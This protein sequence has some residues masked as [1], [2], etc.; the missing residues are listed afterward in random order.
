MKSVFVPLML[1]A[2]GLGGCRVKLDVD[3][4]THRWERADGNVNATAADDFAAGDKVRVKQLGIDVD[5]ITFV[6][7]GG[8]TVK[9]DANIT[10]VSVSARVVGIGYGA[11]AEKDAASDANGRVA[12]S[13]KVEKEGDTW[14]VSCGQAENGDVDSGCEY[15]DVRVPAGSAD[16]PTQLSVDSAVGGVEIRIGDAASIDAVAGLGKIYVEANPVQ[17]AEIKLVSDGDEVE[18]KVP[19]GLNADAVQLIG[20]T[21][22][23]EPSTCDFEGASFDGTTFQIGEQGVG[24]RSI[25]ADAGEDGRVRLRK[26]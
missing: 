15:L 26:L 14:V 22:G 12:E 3:T 2:V 9:T 1:L 4:K 24:A 19:A 25:R 6:S 16:A 21:D 8:V 10:K 7:N 11:E 18:L 13:V 23:E 5:G 20:R 17:G